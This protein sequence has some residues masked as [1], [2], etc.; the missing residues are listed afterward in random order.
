MHATTFPKVV[1]FQDCE[2][3][4][5]PAP[6]HY[7]P[8]AERILK[9]D[10]AQTAINAFASADG[11]F[12]CGIWE[13]QPGK[14]RVVFSESEFCHLLAGVIVVEGD[15]GSKRTFKAGD[16]FVCPAGFTGTWDIVEAAKKY[17]AFYE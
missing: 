11:R 16:A 15:D 17:Y 14:W 13:S 6:Q 8:E 10:P 7:R 3:A 2:A 4:Q 9:G 1:S 12:N 5:D